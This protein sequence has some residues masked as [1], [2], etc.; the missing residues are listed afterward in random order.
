MKKSNYVIAFV[1][2]AACCFVSFQIVGKDRRQ[3]H[4]DATT[5]HSS[6]D[7]PGRVSTAPAARAESPP[8]KPEEATPVEDGELH[9]PYVVL[10]EARMDDPEA[11]A[12]FIDKYARNEAERARM[13]SYASYTKARK[14]IKMGSTFQSLGHRLLRG[15]EI[16]KINLPSFDGEDFEVELSFDDFLSDTQGNH[17]GTIGGDSYTEVVISYYKDQSGGIVKIPA[18][19]LYIAYTPHTSDVMI[20]YDLDEGAYE[21]L[22]AAG[23]HSHPDHPD[24]PTHFHSHDGGDHA[25]SHE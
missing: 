16:K 23:H 15:E 8:K 3:R 25:H 4:S 7:L 19:G 20:I 9:I 1:A 18:K 10:D 24:R 2:V 21:E 22:N 12:R 13:E 11:V 17:F 5:E 6:P 14:A